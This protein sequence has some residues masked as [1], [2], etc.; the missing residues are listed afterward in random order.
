VPSTGPKRLLDALP[1]TLGAKKNQ[2]RMIFAAI[3]RAGYPPGRA[4]TLID[5]FL[6]GGSIS[7]LA[8][9]LGY[10]VVSGDTSPRSEAVG[11]A[12]VANSQV[13][14]EPV[15]L[16]RAFQTS[17]DRWFIPPLK[18]L[19]WPEDCLNLLAS[20][21]RAAEGYED[22]AKRALLRLLMVKVASH[23]SIYG[24]PRM[25]AH[26]RIRE[27][28]WDALTE[29][30]IARILTPQTRPRQMAQRAA[31]GLYGITFSNG[32][33]NE[34]VRG[35]VLDLLAGRDADV[36]YLDPPYP[37]TEGYGRNYVGIDSI[38]ENRELSV[39][40]SRFSE[41]QGWRHLE[42]VLDSAARIPLVVLSVGGESQH[43]TVDDLA[44]LMEATGRKVHVETIEYTLL[45]SRRT[46]KSDRKK[47]W[48]LTG[49]LNSNQKEQ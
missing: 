40:E 16:A 26:Q 15:D 27:K 30:Q 5:P 39:V 19:P 8:K 49:A 17:P 42:A 29:G 2:A 38:L 14:L 47:E 4:H 24:Q 33:R 41:P 43:V 11:L 18:Q 31:R 37:D 3:A 13:Q 48:V 46:A 25:T 20:I 12:L 21:C 23:I 9:A 44:G 1:N 45:H 22:P 10:Q 34:F 35:D 6:G 28:N 32:Q 36:L 7:V